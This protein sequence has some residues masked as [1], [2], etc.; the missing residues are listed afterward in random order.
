MA[1]QRPAPEPRS[2]PRRGKWASS[3]SPDGE[4]HVCVPCKAGSERQ[5]MISSDVYL[6]APERLDSFVTSGCGR[7]CDGGTSH[8]GRLRVAAASSGGMV[9][10]RAIR[11]QILRMGATRAGGPGQHRTAKSQITGATECVCVRPACCG[12]VSFSQHHVRSG[13][14]PARGRDAKRGGRSWKWT[15]HRGGFQRG[16]QG[17]RLQLA[18]AM[19]RSGGAGPVWARCCESRAA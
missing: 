2:R 10:N 1:A 14:A 19:C 16:F 3:N 13:L 17:G 6:G 4:G 9:P 18:L 11:S 12:Q 15:G 7:R 5:A 8:D